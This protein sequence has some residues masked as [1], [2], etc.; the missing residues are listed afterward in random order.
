[1]QLLADHPA[2]IVAVAEICWREWG[3]SPDPPD[4]ASWVASTAREAGRDGLPI[5]WVALDASGAALG[6]VGLIAYDW[7][8]W[9]ER[10]PWVAGMIVAPD[11]RGQGIGGRL[12][13]RLEGWARDRGHARVWVATGGR[14]IAF[15]RR[16][17]WEVIEAVPHDSGE[18][19]TLLSKRL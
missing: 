11:R 8:D 7:D 2:A 12:M 1:M 16:C 14:A 6:S 19:A 4:L 5:K 10:T 18:M 3:Q 17:G 9:P 15:Y 13:A